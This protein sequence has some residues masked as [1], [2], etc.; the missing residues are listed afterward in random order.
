[1][2]HYETVRILHHHGDNDWVPMD[3][4]PEHDSAAH[5]PERA[6]L[7]GARIFKCRTCDEQIAIADPATSPGGLL[8]PG[9]TP[10]DDP[11]PEVRDPEDLPTKPEA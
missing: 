11:A 9:V 10:V 7:R 1:M 6:W 5:D 3:Q 4:M 8:D 2:F